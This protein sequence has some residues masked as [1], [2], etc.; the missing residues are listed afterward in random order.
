MRSIGFLKRVAGDK[1]GSTLMIAAFAMPAVIGAAGLGV[2]TIQ[3][4]L[5]KHQIQRAADSAAMAGAYAVGQGK[6]AEASATADLAK[7]ADLTFTRTIEN[8]PTSGAFAGNT[9]AVRVILQTSRR[10][11]FSSL[12]IATPP[13][14][15]AEATAAIVNGSEH[16]LISLEDGTEPGITVTG[17]ATVTLGCGVVSNSRATNAIEAGGSSQVR[18]D[19]I[20]AVGGLSPSS[21]YLG[22]PKLEP[23][24]LKQADPFA[25]LPNPTLPTCDG[26]SFN[27]GPK[28]TTPPEPNKCY[29]GMDIKG[30]V[31]FPPGTYYINGSEFSAG[32]QAKISGTGVTIILTS[33]TAATQPSTI[34]KVNINAGAQLNFTA[35]LTGPYANILMYQDR[36]AEVGQTNQINGNSES[37]IEGALYFPRQDLLYNGTSGMDT[38]CL[39]I[40]SRRITMSGNST[41]TN[42]CPPPP[43]G[44]TPAN[45]FV[46][47]RVRLVG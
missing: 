18:A 19:P 20:T 24:S 38:S 13:A 7:L 35:P 25:S 32:S 15:R 45:T 5:W 12:F 23:Y 36:R 4:T 2:D 31:V 16:C 14:I 33:T 30:T 37:Q 11:P 26:T 28:D 46:G 42:A 40:V 34:A 17:N 44:T 8:A 29:N 27:S 9:N 41:I 10:L 1:R 39:K 22:N 21:A 47:Q 6:P 3:W 43:G